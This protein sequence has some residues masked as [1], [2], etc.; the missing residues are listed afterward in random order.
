[1]HSLPR[2]RNLIGALSVPSES[3]RLEL[4][5]RF[6]R[7]ERFLT[8]AGISAVLLFAEISSARKPKPTALCF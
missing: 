7:L 1:M 8:G 6:E 4:F 5:E 3:K 2:Q